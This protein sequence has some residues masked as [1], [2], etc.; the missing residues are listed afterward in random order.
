MRYKLYRC[1]PK[2]NI[3]RGDYATKEEAIAFLQKERFRFVE[4]E[5][6]KSYT[7]I[8]ELKD[9]KS[10]KPKPRFKLDYEFTDDGQILEDTDPELSGTD[11]DNSESSSK[12]DN[13]RD[14]L[15]GV[16]IRNSMR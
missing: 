4:D 15:P 13:K 16:S 14:K 3:L 10:I 9:V 8:E 7:Q 2:K 6:G 11:T 5:N 12:R 1:L